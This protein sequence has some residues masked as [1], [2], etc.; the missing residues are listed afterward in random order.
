MPARRRAQTT[1]AQR[2]ARPCTPA[3]ELLVHRAKHHDQLVDPKLQKRCD[4]ASMGHKHVVALEQQLPVQP[5]LSQRRQSVQAQHHGCS[6]AKLRRFKAQPVPP[7]LGIKTPRR[8][9]K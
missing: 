3:A 1:A 4:I 9:L 8:I 2:L 7:V 6:G 5:D